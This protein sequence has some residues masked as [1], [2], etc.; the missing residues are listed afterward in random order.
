M[1][2][3]K[4]KQLI[5]SYQQTYIF[6]LN[7]IHQAISE[8]STNTADISIEQFFVLREIAENDGISAS[9]LALCL[10]VNKS[11][12]TPKLKKLEEKGYIRREKNEKDKR[13]IVL[14]ITKKGKEIYQ[15][16]EQKLE[17]LVNE[18]LEILGEKDSEQFLML[19]E[20]I[21]KSVI[22]TRR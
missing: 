3:Q 19:Y 7:Q 2:K 6:A 5:H 20:K 15:E 13:A 22:Q 16:C 18:W 4:V 12:V 11:A 9:D 14:T 10:L 1:E 8:L 21:T 17:N